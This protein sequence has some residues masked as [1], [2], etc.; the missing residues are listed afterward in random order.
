[1]C[2]AMCC[3]RQKRLN[4]WKLYGRYRRRQLGLY[5]STNSPN[6]HRDQVAMGSGGPSPPRPCGGRA[7]PSLLRY[8]VNYD[9]K[10]SKSAVRVK[11][12][13]TIIYERISLS[14]P[15]ERQ[16]R[17]RQPPEGDHKGPHSAPHRPRPY[18]D[19]RICSHSR[20][21]VGPATTAPTPSQSRSSTRSSL[22]QSPSCLHG[23]AT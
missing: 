21:A 20:L 8:L 10:V 3:L 12:T 11:M 4:A 14:L 6:L 19:L 16:Y 1:M 9:Q 13:P 18:Y 7:S 23:S 5:H 22:P 17:W 15:P 2:A